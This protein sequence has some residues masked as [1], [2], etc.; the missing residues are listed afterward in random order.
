MGPT[1]LVPTEATSRSAFFERKIDP[2][3]PFFRCRLADTTELKVSIIPI[4]SGC[5]GFCTLSTSERVRFE[6]VG[7]ATEGGTFGMKF[8]SPGPVDVSYDNVQNWRGRLTSVL[9]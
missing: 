2:V 8:P 6:N 5:T 9:K 1:G 7:S 4:S 3:T